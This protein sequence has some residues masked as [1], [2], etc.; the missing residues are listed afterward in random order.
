MPPTAANLSKEQLKRYRPFSGRKRAGSMHEA[1][2]VAH[3]LIRSGRLQPARNS[4]DQRRRNCGISG[5]IALIQDDPGIIVQRNMAE[6]FM[7]DT[8]CPWTSQKRRCRPSR[9]SGSSEGPGLRDGHEN[10]TFSCFLRPRVIMLRALRGT[11]PAFGHPAKTR[12][13][14]ASADGCRHRHIR[15]GF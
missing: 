5:T 15:C 12:S 6:K 14:R 7:N 10:I 1:M 9:S 8:F 4:W 3:L 13:A 2:K 11:L